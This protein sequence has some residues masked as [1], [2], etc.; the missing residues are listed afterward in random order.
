MLLG[1]ASIKRGHPER[2]RGE[3]RDTSP[4][5][6]GSLLWLIPLS[7]GR[8]PKNIVSIYKVLVVEGFFLGHSVLEI[9]VD[10]CRT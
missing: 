10:M 9:T 7:F 6:R 1:L 3:S 8:S 2:N 4:L 5:P